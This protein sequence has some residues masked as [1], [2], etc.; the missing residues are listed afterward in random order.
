MT[1]T[2][3]LWAALEKF[4][5]RPRVLIALDFDGTLAKLV[6]NPAEARPTPAAAAALPVLASA[7]NIDLALVSGRDGHTLASLAEPPLGTHLIGSHGA[8]IGLMTAAGFTAEQLTLSAAQENLLTQVRSALAE[9]ASQHEGV[10]VEEK[11]AAA[12]IHTRPATES[13][14]R[15]ATRQT[16]AG[17]AQLPGTVV[18]QGKEVVEIGVLS[19]TKGDAITRLRE[20]IGNPPVL[21]MGDDVTDEHAFAVLNDGHQARPDHGDISVKVGPGES[22][23]RY[24]V[25]DPD[26]VAETLGFLARMLR[27]K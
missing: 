5:G 11:P 21:F 3:Q 15:Q 10:W 22:A 26:A 14:A 12:A 23:A 13:S 8:E 27:D 16:L 9:I 2:E 1:T 7:P 25:T 17:P 19:A 6:A 20:E 4:L 18:L 24:R